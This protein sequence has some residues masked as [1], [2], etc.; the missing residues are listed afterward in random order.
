M[1]VSFNSGFLS[2]YAQQWDCWVIW[3]L[4]FHFLRHLHTVLHSG[5]TSSHSHKQWKRVTFSPHPLQNLLF[6]KF[7]MAAILTNVRWYLMV[8]LICMYLIM[9]D[10]EHLIM[11]LLD[12][13]MSSLEKCLFK[14]Q[15]SLLGSKITADGD[16][17]QEIKRCLL[18]GRKV[19]T[20]IDSMLKSRDITLP[21]K[22][23]L[24]KTVVFLI[25]MYVRFG[26]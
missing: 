19:M 7:L 13:C 26:L 20:N 18:L 2:V 22:V 15:N 11:C 24:V 5:C 1:Y 3:Q 25:V 9:A 16:C 17:S 23:H 21:S 10:V 8:V 4:H 6:V 12:I 14:F